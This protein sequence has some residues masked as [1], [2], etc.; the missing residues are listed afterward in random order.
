MAFGAASVLAA[1]SFGAHADC[2]SRD[3]GVASATLAPSTL[4]VIRNMFLDPREPLL[5]VCGSP[6]SPPVAR[7]VPCSAGCCWSWW[8]S[9]FL[10][11]VP[12]MLLLLA[13]GHGSSP[14]TVIRILAVWIR[15][16]CA[17]PRGCPRGDL[18]DQAN[19]RRWARV[20]S[21]AA[22]I[23]GVVIGVVFVQ[24]Q[25]ALAD[26]L[27]D[28]SLFKSVAFSA[29]LAINIVGF[30]VAFGTFLSSPSTCSSCSE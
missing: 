12:V 17:V 28:L 7:S 22:M 21:V 9:V 11:N 24:R 8:G 6:A 26:P 3:L 20:A 18:W 25:K 13:V 5:W 4:S 10:V 19:R 1:F 30:F 29:S 23:V 15:Q 16:R 2:R 14:N 27:I